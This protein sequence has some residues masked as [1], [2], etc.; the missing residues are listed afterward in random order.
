MYIQE[1]ERRAQL[2]KAQRRS[3]GLVAT[4]VVRLPLFG[5]RVRLLFFGGGGGCGKTRI[6]T[7]AHAKLLRRFY[8]PKGLVLKAFANKPARLIGGTSTHGLIKCRGGQSLNIAHLRVQND[9]QRRALAAVW[10]PV[11]ALVKDEFTQQPGALDNALAVR[12]MY[13][14]QRYHD[15]RCEDYAR[16][17]TNYA[18]IPY[19]VTAGGPLQFPPVPAVSSLLAEPEGQTKEHRMLTRI[20]HAW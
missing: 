16:P 12:A 14:R 6:I 3:E 15:L 9:K 8:G 7:S 1:V 2:T 17:Q 18:A 10:A 13:G 20:A 19:V 5:P 4:D 11:G